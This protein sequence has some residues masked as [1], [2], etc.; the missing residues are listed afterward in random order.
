MLRRFL[1]KQRHGFTLLEAM[2]ALLILVLTMPLLNAQM[3]VFMAA[4]RVDN[5]HEVD[6]WQLA[7]CQLQRFLS[8][9]QVVTCSPHRVKLYHQQEQKDYQLETYRS[10]ATHLML[11]LRGATQGHMPLFQQLKTITLTYQAPC[12]KLTGAF[13]HSGQTFQQRYYLL[14]KIKE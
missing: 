5:M 4:V 7:N 11:R 1:G 2:V 9:C 3:K 13:R 8:H 14:P 6:N 10:D 12:L